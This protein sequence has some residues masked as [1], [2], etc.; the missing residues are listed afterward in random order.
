MQKRRKLP[1]QA[2]KKM[3]DEQGAQAVVLAGT[4][5]FVAFN[6]YECGFKYVDSALVH[7]DAIHRASMENLDNKS[8]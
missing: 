5:L 1:F 6:G 2:G 3:C 8:L 7:I 4:D